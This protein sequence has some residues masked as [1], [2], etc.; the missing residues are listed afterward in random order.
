M[1]LTI[2]GATGSIGVSTL[3]VVARHPDRF[4][5]VALTG[6][7]QVAA[8]AAQCR[9]FRP[10]YA[11]V[12]S[13]TAAQQLAGLLRE[14]SVR[15]EVLFG[16]DALTEVASLPEVD[17]V[18]AAIVGA[19]G[20]PPTL[21]A[22]RAGKRVLLANKEALVMAGEVFMSEARRAGALLL[23][24]DSEHNAVFQSMPYDYSGDMARGGVRRILLTA[25]GG[26]FRTT[27]LDALT[28]ITPEQA[29]AHPKWVM[30][31]KI[32]V[33]SAT[34]MNKGLEVIEAH[35]LFNAPAEKIEVVI[36]PQSVIHSLV[37]YEDGSVLAQ[38]GNP[39]MRTP[40]AHAMAWPE[41]IDSGVAPLDLFAVG[42]LNF[43][44]PDP[45]RFP[46]LDLAY[47]ALRAEGN[48]AA[49][50][51]AANEVAVT[52]FLE[53]RLPFLGIAGL[54][55]ATL[56]AVPQ[57]ALPDLAAVLEADRQG[58]TMAMELLARWGVSAP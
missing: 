42:Q 45:E 11:V 49:V 26:P 27:P 20:L 21:A 48:A 18:M 43:E 29:V 46:C 25:S 6:H 16:A 3:D 41:R 52:A 47:R 57:A 7:S 15:T 13:A 9:Q 12:G 39:D 35:W 31:R 30:G 1:K 5:V 51:N 32:S 23:P 40:I 2:L 10:A 50:L 38:L 44:R 53:C 37:D 33:D 22:A 55:A 54:I 4:E 58:R 17:A 19:A 56:D 36:H 28:Q 8:L 14:A 24:I 34:M